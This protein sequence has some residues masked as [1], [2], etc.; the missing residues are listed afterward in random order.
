[1]IPK[2]WKKHPKNLNLDHF[3]QF[4]D[5][6]LKS[7]D[8]ERHIPVSTAASGQAREPSSSAKIPVIAKVVADTLGSHWDGLTLESL[9][10]CLGIENLTS[11]QKID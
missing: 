6:V 11:T 3:I 7:D 8:P 9:V 1:M 2:S 4:S 5:D 10:S